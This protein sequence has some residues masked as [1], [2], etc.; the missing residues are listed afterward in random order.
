MPIEFPS[1]TKLT[2]AEVNA[3]KAVLIQRLQESSPGTEF[4]RGVVHDLILQLE[5]VV[6]AAQESYADKFRKAGSV[7]AI[8]SDPSLADPELVDQVLSNFLLTRKAGTT[9]IGEITVVIPTARATVVAAGSVFIAFGKKYVASNTFAAKTSA[10]SV[11]TPSDRI[12]F[13]IGDGTYGFNITVQAEENGASTALKQG[14]RLQMLS[15]VGGIISSF[16]NVDFIPGSE[17]ETNLQ[18]VER[19]REGVSSKNFS[20][21]YTLVSLIKSNFASVNDVE[22]FGYGAPEQIRYHGLFPVAHGGRL[23]I[24]VKNNGLPSKSVVDI[25]ATLVEQRLN[26]GL[27]QVSFTRN[28]APGFYEASRIVRLEDK[29]N[30]AIVSGY[31]TINI[32]R[33]F[34]LSDDGTGFSPDIESAV[35]AAFTPYQ[36]CVLQFLDT[37]TDASLVIGTKSKYSFTLRH[38]SGLAQIQTFINNNDIRPTGSDALV[39]AAVPFDVKVSVVV[40]NRNKDY[41]VPVN[42][43]KDDLFKYINS[44]PFNSKL[45]ES[46]IVSIVQNALTEDQSINSVDLRGRIIYPS[47]RIRYI[48]GRMSLS[49]PDNPSNL[50]T[51]RNTAYFLDKSDIQITVQSV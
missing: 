16:A 25:E 12:I 42:A 48:N 39:R 24:S 7:Q 41:V 4:R 51:Q 22:S 32:N 49:V 33:G 17:I 10:S 27:W 13:E 35:E 40:H 38:Q 36:T 5:S 6:H 34:D 20:N 21:K 50:V 47:G 46:N 3:A 23:D 15:P 14:D 30:L 29:S 19:L 26:G 28:I 43:I 2:L 9:S 45:Y 8:E 31:E 1:L 11:I 44:L 18:L 37:D